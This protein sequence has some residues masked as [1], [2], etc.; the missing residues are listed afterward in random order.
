MP[1]VPAL[2][3]G[4]VALDRLLLAPVAHDNLPEMHR[5]HSDPAVWRHLPSGRHAT[6]ERTR[7]MMEHHVADWAHGLGYWTVRLRDTGDFVGVGGCRVRDDV[8][9]NIY[10]RLDPVYQGRGFATQVAQAGMAAAA[11]V[12]PELPVTAILVE[13]NLASKAVAVRL[14]LQC[15]WRGHDAGNPDPDAIRLV[16]ADRPLTDVQLAEITS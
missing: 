11:R 8:A 15:V 14:G 4:V 13:H 1:L 12:R 5:L 10:Y 6:L 16:Y 2:S 9:W 7:E 3:D